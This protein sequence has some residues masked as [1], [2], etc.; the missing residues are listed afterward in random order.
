MQNLQLADIPPKY[1]NTVFPHQ[2]Y[3]LHQPLE[4]LAIFNKETYFFIVKQTINLNTI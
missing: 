4:E 1:N 2:K 3:E